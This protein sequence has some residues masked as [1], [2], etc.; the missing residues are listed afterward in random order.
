MKTWR[1]P[2]RLGRGV[3]L[4][5]LL[6]GLACGPCAAQPD[7][8]NDESQ[9]KAAFLYKFAGYVDWP[10]GFLGSVETPFTIGVLG[11]DPIADEL[12]QIV[13]GRKIHSRSIVVSRLKAGDPLEDVAILFV[14]KG[15]AARLK[16]VRGTLQAQPILVVTEEPAG[17]ALGGM[18]NFLLVDRH[19]RFE[20]ALAPVEKSGLR[21]SSRLLA[22][23]QRVHAE[24]R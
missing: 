18:I 13:Q 16:P 22:V 15:D 19:V 4:W 3:A 9:I 20:V 24:G 21:L 8:P 11:A 6:V 2:W 7:W 12:V 17:L 5:V 10:E 1:S 23:A 14:G